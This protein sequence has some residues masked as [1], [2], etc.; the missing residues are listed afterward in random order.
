MKKLWKTILASLM[1]LSLAACGNGGDL[2]TQS[3]SASS[4]LSVNNGGTYIMA[5]SGEPATLNPDATSDDFNYA[6]VQ[7]LFSRLYK[8]NNLYQAVPDLATSYDLSKDGL[9]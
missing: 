2:P 6:I 4:G 5:Q 8:L 9:T 7:N 3:A 1:T